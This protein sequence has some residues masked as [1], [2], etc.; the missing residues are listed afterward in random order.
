M[1]RVSTLLLI[2]GCLALG[3]VAADG[4][5]AEVPVSS[6]DGS[7]AVENENESDKTTT[8]STTATA[9]T[10]AATTAT[11]STTTAATTATTTS[12]AKPATPALV[13]A[14]KAKNLP[15][16]VIFRPI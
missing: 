12:T 2:A 13:A 8:A 14:T 6:E 5:T 11:A 4:T 3:A 1:K 9:T 10:T 7:D 16:S 15:V